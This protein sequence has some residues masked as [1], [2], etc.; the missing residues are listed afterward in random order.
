MRRA[1]AAG[2]TIISIT[3]HDTV[4]GM[5]PAREA[6]V[7]HGLRL[8]PGIEITSVHNER[9]VH[10]LGYFIDVTCES[11]MAFLRDQRADRIRRVHEMGE[12]LRALGMVIDADALV[13]A[14][15]PGSR[16]IGR[17][18][19]ADALVAAGHAAD[20]N[21]AFERLLGR[22]QPA[23]VPR[24]GLCGPEVI[25]VIHDAGGI[26]SMAHPGVTA[27]DSLIP[28]LA[29]AGLDAIEV[30]HSDHSPEQRRHHRE[31]AERLRLAKSGGSDYHGEGLHRACQLGAIALP[32]EEF[33]GLERC[34]RPQ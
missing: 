31:L 33:A 27:D 18:A 8:V 15:P 29:D 6:A 13:G 5:A 21:D 3:D 2:L 12:R 17:P 28:V 1:A 22:G 30:W 26:A 23:Y 7:P 20:R 19:V 10:I 34:V 32:R 4:A 16:S 11:L 25:E 24:H 9:D 14:A